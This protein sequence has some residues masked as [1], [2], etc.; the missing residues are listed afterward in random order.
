MRRKWDLILR[1]RLL[2]LCALVFSL[3]WLSGLAWGGEVEYKDYYNER[4]GFSFQYP[5]ELRP[6]APPANGDGRTFSSKRSPLVVSGWG[7]H[8]ILGQGLV[9]ASQG[10]I[11]TQAQR[12]IVSP[13][14]D[15]QED[16]TWR[17]QEGE[18]CGWVRMLAVRPP[19][20]APLFITLTCEYP[21]S[22]AP[23]VEKL[24]EQIVNSL[25]WSAPKGSG[26]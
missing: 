26:D 2:L 3:S 17:W 7:Q 11:P 14:G 1:G 9:E 5:K 4:F 21:K 25:R 23:Q 19:A 12:W 20:S 24:T 8:N 6:Q 22:A 18:R 13:L 15:C 10:Y 16:I